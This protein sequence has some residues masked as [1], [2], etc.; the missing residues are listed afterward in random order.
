MGYLRAGL[1]FAAIDK[2]DVLNK[3]RRFT[4]VGTIEVGFP[5]F[6]S[7]SNLCV[8]AETVIVRPSGRPSGLSRLAVTLECHRPFDRGW[9]ASVA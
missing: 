6:A 7:Y 2:I 1:D 9:Q 8:S 3:L 4:M 5:K